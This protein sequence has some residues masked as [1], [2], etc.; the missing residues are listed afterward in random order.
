M[1]EWVFVA[2]DEGT[3]ISWITR[4][5]L[6]IVVVF[7]A[8]AS[9]ALSVLIN[10]YEEYERVHRAT[11]RGDLYLGLSGRPRTVSRNGRDHTIWGGPYHLNV[12]YYPRDAEVLQGEL[13]RLEVRSRETGE[14]VYSA[15]RLIDTY[16]KHRGDSGGLRKSA[17]SF[18]SE[19]LEIPYQD[20]EITF[21]YRIYSE[22]DVLLESG[23]I[24]TALKRDHY[25]GMK[26]KGTP[27]V[28]DRSLPAPETISQRPPGA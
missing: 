25:R 22:E 28:L 2:L 5:A 16:R 20:L 1:L 26:R 27:V 18:G 24:A 15:S 19:N 12:Q 6:A 8:G 23:R 14:I 11:E 4:F 13:T 10:T 7:F 3:P 17:L 9:C 21:E